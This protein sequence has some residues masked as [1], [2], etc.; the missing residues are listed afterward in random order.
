VKFKSQDLDLEKTSPVKNGTKRR[1]EPIENSP[2]KIVYVNPC[3]ALQ[4]LIELWKEE[5][6][7]RVK[8]MLL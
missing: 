7:R 3:S 8:E 1:K 5:A 4:I 6:L 2:V